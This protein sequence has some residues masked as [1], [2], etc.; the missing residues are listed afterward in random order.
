MIKEFR[1]S[2]ETLHNRYI[3]ISLAKEANLQEKSRNILDS[4]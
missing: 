2:L 4:H 1:V 3:S